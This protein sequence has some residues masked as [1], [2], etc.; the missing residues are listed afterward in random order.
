MAPRDAPWPIGARLRR[1]ED[2][3]LLRG[4]GRFLAD[5]ARPGMLHARFLRSPVAHARIAALD[6]GPARAIPGVVGAWAAAD[7]APHLA[8][9]R[10]PVAMPAKAVRAEADP[11]VLAADEICHA[12]EAMAVVVAESRL[13]AEDAVAALRPDLVPLP[14]LADA[15]AALAPGAAPVRAGLADNLIAVFET[16]YG[17][18]DAALAGAPIRLTRR[19]RLNK[20]GG[21]SVET[22]GV[23]A[24][25]DPVRRDGLILWSSAQMPH[26]VRSVVAATLGMPEAAL[27]VVAPDVGGGFGPKFVTYP[28]EAALAALARLLRRPVRWIE[29]RAE[30]FVATT[31]ERLQVW[32]VTVAAEADGRLRGLSGTLLQDCG[33]YLPYGLVVPQNA[34]TNLLGP[35]RVPAYR[36]AVRCAATNLVPVTPTRGAGRPQGTFVMERMLDAIADAAGLPRA[37]VRRRNLIPADAMP[38][39]TP[40]STRD[41]NAMIYDSGDYPACLDQALEAAEALGFGRRAPSVPG[42]RVGVGLSCYVEGTGRGPFE[43]ARVRVDPSGRVVVATGAAA[44]GQGTATVLAQVAAGTLGADLAAIDVE[45]GDTAAMPHG[46]GAF[47]S[48]QAPVAGASV[49]IAAAA[50][51]DKALRVAAARLEA[52]PADLEIVGGVA[53]IVGAPGSG[54]PLGEIARSLSGMPGFPLPAGESAGLEADAAFEPPGLCYANGVHVAEVEV[55]PETA[56]ARVTRMLVVHDCGLALNPTLVEG[57]VIGGTLHGIGMA[58][59]E[60]VLVDPAGL[61]RNAGYPATVLPGAWDAP[62]VTVLHRE[63]PTPFNLLG[64]KGAGEGGTIGA[65]AAVIAAVEDALRPLRLD[66][67]DLPMTPARLAARIAEVGG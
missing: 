25:P 21:H 11:P 62:E 27:R 58:L 65:P 67:S 33:A 55:D 5:L 28:E 32:D 30:N 18:P 38:Y 36:L 61:P 50:V 7:L 35:Y 14:T 20:G 22:R 66:L 63:S 15:E 44:Q 16:A 45:A 43:S 10:L 3:P 6:L 13:T 41:G 56:E 26:R 40:L 64:A 53:R 46:L 31:Q 23:L 9:A 47:A 54:I 8:R 19:F 37:E 60:E 17:D 42:R 34:S 57:Q 29:D 4:E 48:R 49:R 12:G 59:Q 24:E 51:R 1:I 2:G 39:R 52:D